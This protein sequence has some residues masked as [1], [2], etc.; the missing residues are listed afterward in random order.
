M[1]GHI[2]PTSSSQ[3]HSP[4]SRARSGRPSTSP[5]H[6]RSSPPYSPPPRVEQPPNPPELPL[7]LLHPTTSR[8]Y[9]AADAASAPPA[10]PGRRGRGWMPFSG[11]WQDIKARAPYYVSDWTDAWNYR[12][13]PSTWFIFFA[14]VLPGLAFSLDLIEET[15]LYG[16]QEVL[17]AS[18]MA[19]FVAAVFGGQPLLISGVTGPITVFNKTIFDIFRGRDDW[20]YLHFMGW[21]YL[22]GAILHWIAAALNAV[23][24]LKYVTRFSCDTFGFYVAAVYVQYGIQVVTRQ[25]GQTSTPSAF[26]GILLA[27]ITL[28]LP[29]YFNALARSGYISKQF[30][31]FCADYGMPLTI[32]AATGM[33]YWGRFNPFVHEEDMT[34]PVVLHSFRPAAGRA[35][36]VEFWLLP[37]KYV[38][39]AFP[40][41]VILF[42]LF[43]FDA[44]VSALIAQGSEFPLRKPAAFHWDFFLLGITTF[45]AGLLGV[46]APNGLIPQAPLHTASLVVMGYEDDEVP[47]TESLDELEAE[48]EGVGEARGEGEKRPR[49]TST[50]MA[51]AEAGLKRRPR[52]A[53][54]SS[55]ARRVSQVS[56][57]LRDARARQRLL[58]AERATR[59]E[60]PV[61]VVEQRVSNLAQGALCLVLM[62]KPFE[63]VLGLIPKGVLAGLF[64]YMGTDALLSSGVTSKMLYLVREKRARAPSDPLERVRTSRIALFVLVEL[65]GFGA[66]FAITQTIA[67]IGFPIIIMLLVP[68]RYFVI[69]R[70]GFTPAELDILDGPV[71]SPFTM[72]SVD[73]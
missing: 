55:L 40:F 67:A 51:E 17:L 1:E 15:G 42:V 20:N 10:E 19:A 60:V 52:A 72:Q 45:I 71:A 70:M 9:D 2:S 7:T 35:W 18:F 31:R 48:D 34:L 26:L 36:L 49:S 30:R 29:H 50:A 24:G 16:V 25:F 5:T 13:I 27:L 44:N 38:G 6:V 54:G 59:R 58:A 22:W 3:P 73:G 12:V 66:T 64:W 4:V 43:Y 63:H 56:T 39:M 47:L 53:S 14:N 23:K 28:V 65:I 68:V 62:T 11:M 8:L 46:P 69:P 21:V 37:G 57:S 61:A 32:V 41:G 33:A